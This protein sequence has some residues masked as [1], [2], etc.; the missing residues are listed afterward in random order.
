M[1]SR[2]TKW[3]AVL[4]IACAICGCG[5]DDKD[6]ELDETAIRNATI[7][8][9]EAFNNQ[10]AESVASLWTEDATYVDFTDHETVQ[11]RAEIEKYFKERFEAEG[12]SKIDI[13]IN[14]I[15]FQNATSATEK[16]VASVTY[17][18]GSLE[19]TAFESKYIKSDS[20]WLL[21]KRVSIDLVAAPTHYE[22]LK[23][24]DWFVGGWISAGDDTV[25]TK[26][27]YGWDHNKNFLIHSFTMD[28]LSQKELTGEEVIGWDPIEKKIRSWTFDSDGGFGQGTWSKED[29]SW[30]VTVVYILPDGK[31]ASA[32][33]IYTKVDGTAYTF[34][35]VSRDIDGKLL[36]NIG[37]YKTVRAEVEG[38]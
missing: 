15:D 31:R 13:T 24:L 10:D 30:Y 25:V 26:S 36:P 14:S 37:P 7:S 17:E 12:K 3:V 4:A 5:E 16:G 9:R 27:L 11:G 33:H 21:K 6:F 2:V 28:V 20:D 19:K 8:Y 29:D 23:D 18:D 38:V 32:T 22:H 34:S 35:S 1:S